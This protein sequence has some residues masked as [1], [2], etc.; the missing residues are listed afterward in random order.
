MLSTILISHTDSG[1]SLDVPFCMQQA[2]DGR[3]KVTENGLR[4]RAWV[5]ANH[6]GDQ[7]GVSWPQPDQ[8]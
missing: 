1:S 4:V 2:V 5:P 8:L 7:A 3:G 6:E